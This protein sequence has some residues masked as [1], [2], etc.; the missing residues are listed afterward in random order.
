V[1]IGEG[2]TEIE[3]GTLATFHC[4]S[5][6][7]IV[8]PFEEVLRE[9]S[10]MAVD[11]PQFNPVHTAKDDMFKVDEHGLIDYD[12][13]EHETLNETDMDDDFKVDQLQNLT[14]VV[15]AKMATSTAEYVCEK[16]EWMRIHESERPF[17]LPTCYK[18]RD[19]GKR[20]ILLF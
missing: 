8:R 4:A 5:G 7:F 15:P 19:V 13:Y 14:L 9:K 12:P 3:D 6:E 17:D 16:G 18:E 11:F 1:I 20:E 2:Q 10:L